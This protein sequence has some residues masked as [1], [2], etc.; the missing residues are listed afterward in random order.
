MISK[1]HEI[2][3]EVDGLLHDTK[4]HSMLVSNR[5]LISPLC[6]AG[7]LFLSTVAPVCIDYQNWDKIALF[8]YISIIFSVHN[9]T[10]IKL[11]KSFCT[12]WYMYVERRIITTL[13]VGHTLTSLTLSLLGKLVRYTVTSLTLSPLGRLVGHTV[14]SLTLSPL[15]RLVGHTVTSLTLSPLGKLVGNTV[16]SLSLS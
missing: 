15:G 11:S 10:V 2:G 7:S 9:W 13:S 6:T 1:V 5:I 3:K 14:M 4:V 16:M 12:F 8:W